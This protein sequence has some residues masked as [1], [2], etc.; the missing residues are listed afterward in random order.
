MFTSFPVEKAITCGLQRYSVIIYSISTYVSRVI[1]I[2][3]C[4]FELYLMIVEIVAEVC[5]DVLEL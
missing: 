5:V 4:L 2:A 1:K 3:A